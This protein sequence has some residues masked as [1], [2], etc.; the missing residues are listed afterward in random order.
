MF[1]M[2]SAYYKIFEPYNWPTQNNL[3]IQ[4]LLKTTN[5]KFVVRSN[6]YIEKSDC[7]VKWR[8]KMLNFV[9]KYCENHRFCRAIVILHGKNVA[10]FMTS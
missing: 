8:E 4:T 7:P 3:I 5:R 6:K 2:T 10:Y 9:I 1:E